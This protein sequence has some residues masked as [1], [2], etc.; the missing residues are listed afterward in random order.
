MDKLKVIRFLNRE[1]EK[2]RGEPSKVREFYQK[3]KDLID[4]AFVEV[5][6]P[7][8]LMAGLKPELA[9]IIGVGEFIGLMGKKA[10]EEKKMFGG[11]VWEAGMS[12][13]RR[14][15]EVI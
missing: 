13:K 1:Y 12:K 3:H 8:L 9:V 2:I 15:E 6:V 7:S 5:S 11:S 14:L 4:T 10:Y